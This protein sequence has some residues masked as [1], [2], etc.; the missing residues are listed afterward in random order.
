[1]YEKEQLA[2]TQEKKYFWPVFNINCI[3]NIQPLT[4]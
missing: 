1:M 3:M 4:N 2:S